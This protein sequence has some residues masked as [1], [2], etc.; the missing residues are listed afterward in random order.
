MVYSRNLNIYIKIFYICII[1]IKVK[2]RFFI[3]VCLILLHH[4]KHVHL[5]QFLLLIYEQWN[6]NQHQK[7][8]HQF[9]PYHT[10]FRKYFHYYGYYVSLSSNWLIVWNCK[11]FSEL[12]ILSNIHTFIIIDSL[13]H[14]S[15]VV[16]DLNF[17]RMAYTTV[18]FDFFWW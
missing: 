9:Y 13:T 8:N 12:K 2:S 5:H 4:N 15:F 7:V 3:N 1:L 10:S 16:F 18:T 11:I 14:F 17:I 6:T